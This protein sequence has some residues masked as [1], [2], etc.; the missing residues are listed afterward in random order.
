MSNLFDGV[1]NLRRL[2]DGKRARKTARSLGRRADRIGRNLRGMGAD[3]SSVVPARMRGRR[4]PRFGA[5]PTVVV[6]GAGLAT[7]GGML[8]WDERRRHAMRQR[9]EDVTA[10]VGASVNRHTEHAM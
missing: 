6:A 5:L 4:G 3:L 9:L 1:R 2:V 8:L 10:S 7:I